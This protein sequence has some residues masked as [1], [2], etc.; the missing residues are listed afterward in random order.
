MKKSLSKSN[1]DNVTALIAH[2]LTHAAQAL[3]WNK[4][5]RCTIDSEFGAYI[6]QIYVLQELGH[7]DW[8][9]NSFGVVYDANGKFSEARLYSWIRKNYECSEN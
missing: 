6:V 7:K 9:T 2:E 4:P 8:L 3:E 1:G 5:C